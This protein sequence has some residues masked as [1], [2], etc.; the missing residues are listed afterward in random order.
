MECKFN[1]AW[2]GKC[3]QTADDSGYCEE[4]KKEK[5]CSCGSQATHTCYETA[6][7]VCGVPLCNDCEHTLCDNGCNSQGNLP[8]G[9]GTHCKKT[10]QVYKPWYMEE[11]WKS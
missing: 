8:E 4:H 5:C 1:I 7:F 10:E 2:I 6:G 9:L 3:E 11:K